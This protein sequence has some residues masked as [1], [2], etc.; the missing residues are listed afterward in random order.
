MGVANNYTCYRQLYRLVPVLFT[1]VQQFHPTCLRTF[2]TFSTL[3]LLN[4]GRKI[5]MS[6]FISFQ[7]SCCCEDNSKKLTQLVQD[8]SNVEDMPNNL[9]K[10]VSEP[11]L[12]W[13]VPDHEPLSPQHHL[14]SSCTLSHHLN[15]SCTLSHHLNTMWATTSPSVVRATTS[16]PVILW[17]SATIPAVLTHHHSTS[18]PNWPRE[19]RHQDSRHWDAPCVQIW[20][21]DNQEK[22]QECYILSHFF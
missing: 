21:D 10:S 3:Y 8:I 15:T 14:N 2:Y 20:H 5:F 13:E 19:L 1:P 22:I 18:Q 17:A 9:T 4:F 11:G 6:S 12:Y 16:I 7:G